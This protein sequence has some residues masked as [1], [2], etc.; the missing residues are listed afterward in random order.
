[1]NLLSDADFAQ[2]MT[3]AMGPAHAS[4]EKSRAFPISKQIDYSNN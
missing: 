3:A 1:M 4:V 2:N